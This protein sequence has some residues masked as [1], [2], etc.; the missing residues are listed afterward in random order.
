MR[1]ELRSSMLVGHDMCMVYITYMVM[2][3]TLFL[4]T[5]GKYLSQREEVYSLYACNSTDFP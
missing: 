3:R 2:S 1:P 4:G 5:G